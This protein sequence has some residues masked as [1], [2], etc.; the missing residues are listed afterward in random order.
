[1]D[2]KIKSDGEKLELNP[3]DSSEENILGLNSSFRNSLFYNR[4]RQKHSVTY[5]YLV[6]KGKSLLSIGSQNVQNYSHQIQYF[7]YRD[8]SKSGAIAE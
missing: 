4:G 7:H 3:F 8:R 5:S 2:R 6:N 1:M